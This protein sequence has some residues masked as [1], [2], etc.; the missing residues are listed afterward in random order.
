MSRVEYPYRHLPLRR[1]GFHRSW[2][3]DHPI[4]YVSYLRQGVADGRVVAPHSAT[5]PAITING[6]NAARSWPDGVVS[7]SM[8]ISLGQAR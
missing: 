8:C 2:Q 5:D 3:H 1:F 4:T 6:H 7:A